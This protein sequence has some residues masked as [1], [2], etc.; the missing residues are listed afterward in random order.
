MH[1]TVAG[2]TRTLLKLHTSFAHSNLSL[3]RNHLNG[4]ISHSVNLILF[5]RYNGDIINFSATG[6]DS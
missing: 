1:F 2:R 4:C 6:T 3:V 5:T